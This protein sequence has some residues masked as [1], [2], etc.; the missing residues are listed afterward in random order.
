[1]NGR[2]RLQPRRRA[3]VARAVSTSQLPVAPPRNT[4]ASCGSTTTRSGE[5][6]HCTSPERPKVKLQR[7]TK[8]SAVITI[9]VRDTSVRLDQEGPR[10]WDWPHFS[11]PVF[12]VGNG[13]SLS[14]TP[15]LRQGR[16]LHTSPA[17]GASLSLVLAL[18][19][20]SGLAW[21]VHDLWRGLG[22]FKAFRKG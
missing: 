3:G 19:L 14:V 17:L 8:R 21:P 1:M 5:R 20:L 2:A 6:D 13:Y 12:M 11:S 7:N 9:A 22:G 4:T 15:A 10:L 16:R 18:P